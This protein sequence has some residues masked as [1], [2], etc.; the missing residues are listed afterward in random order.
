M[1]CQKCNYPHA[2]A[3]GCVSCGWKFDPNLHPELGHSPVDSAEWIVMQAPEALERLYGQSGA[4]LKLQ[5]AYALLN[6]QPAP[7]AGPI[8]SDQV[9]SI[10]AEPV[11]APSFAPSRV[12]EE[13]VAVHPDIAGFDPIQMP[14]EPP[15]DER[16]H[17]VEADAPVE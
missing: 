15:V 2:N 13:D 11:A 9:T 3:L 7:K 1:I 17:A 14:Q 10:V 5:A 16:I 6:A 8:P 4:R 12:H